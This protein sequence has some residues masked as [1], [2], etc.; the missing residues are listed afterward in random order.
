MRSANPPGWLT[1]ALH[2]TT[3]FTK[4]FFRGAWGHWEEPWDRAPEV[5]QVQAGKLTLEALRWPGTGAPLVLL[6]GLNNNAWMWARCASLLPGREILSLSLRGHGGSDSPEDGG[7]DLEATAADVVA[8]LDALGVPRV[9]LGGHSWGGR[10]ALQVAS[11]A[12]ARV[13]RLILADP[14]L[15]RG[16]NPVLAQNPGLVD[17]AFAPERGTF[18][19]HRELAAS[20]RR[21]VYLRRGLPSDRRIWE[22]NYKEDKDGRLRH[23]LPEEGYR[24]I[25][26]RVLTR[27]VSWTLDR[28]A[29]PVLLLRPTFT[30]GF[31]PGELRDLRRRLDLTVRRISGDHCFI[32]SNPVD[33]AKAIQACFQARAEG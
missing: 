24:Q 15:P 30:I 4:R 3:A 33:T 13:R 5:L 8:A 22:A 14:V 21:L 31:I 19:S 17:A 20:A 23:R 1:A 6:H 16:L 27:D 28:V 32:H 29:C 12:S 25:A 9:D 26:R 11:T 2:G 18:S 7:Y 10:V